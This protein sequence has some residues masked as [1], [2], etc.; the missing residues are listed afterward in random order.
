MFTPSA[1]TCCAQVSKWRAFPDG[2][3]NIT[4]GGFEPQDQ[5]AGRDVLFLGSDRPW[6][7]PNNRWTQSSTHRSTGSCRAERRAPCGIERR[8][9]CAVE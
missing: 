3:P 5:V 1:H 2:T 4:L 8:A 6:R 9:P 7:E